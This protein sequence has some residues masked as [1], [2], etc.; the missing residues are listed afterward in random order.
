MTFD[1]YRQRFLEYLEIERGRSQK[2]IQNYDFYLRRFG[3]FASNPNPVNISQ[4]IIRRYR[5]HLNRN[6]EGRDDVNLKKTTQ[7]YH[8][9]ALR[10]FLKY[11]AKN[12]VKS[13]PPEQIELAKHESRRVEHL[14]RD[15]LARLVQAAS[16]IDGLIGLRNKAIAELLFSTGM[17]V[18]ELTSLQIEN[19]N[20]KRDE[21]T[22][23]GKG[24]KH[25]V[26]FLSPEAK[27]T[28]NTYLDARND[29]S[30]ALFVSHDR[31]KEGREVRG[32]T[33][34]TVQRVVERAATEAGITKKITPHVIRHTFAT[35]L[36]QNGADIRSVQA[37]L[38]HESITTTQ[39][40]TH[41]TDKHLHDVHKKFHG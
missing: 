14:D 12:N 4:D 39:I 37:M 28:L 7:N 25:R 41:V 32:I 8:L 40:Y 17:R 29:I 23:T 30:P 19:I 3:E 36:L 35:N 6:I 22:I 1:A 31:A 5:L 20:L 24:S 13:L 2:T 10:A 18:S 26:V 9:I 34:R 38:G 21:F 33:P 11:L 15:E 16:S 27:K